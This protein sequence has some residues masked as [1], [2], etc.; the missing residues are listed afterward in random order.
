MMLLSV[1][2][3]CCTLKMDLDV[4]GQKMHSEISMLSG[5]DDTNITEGEVT[6]LNPYCT[7][8]RPIIYKMNT[9]DA[10]D[11]KEA[12]RLKLSAEL[13]NIVLKIE[14]TKFIKP[15]NLITVRSERLKLNNRVAFFVEQTVISQDSQGLKYSMNCV[16][17]DVYTKSEVKNEF[18]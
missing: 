10:I 3:F 14:T 16:L 1:G 11:I 13:M 9:G 4:N 5:T 2:F 12:V 18:R 8:K 7:A 6:I 17:K 15:G